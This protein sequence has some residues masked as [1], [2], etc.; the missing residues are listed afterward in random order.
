M[1]DAVRLFY[2]YAHEDEDLRNEL[3]GHLKILERRK[4][5]A[6]WHDRRI[7]P[8]RAWDAEIDRYLREAELV[9]LLVSADFIASDYIMGQELA[10][11]MAQHDAGSSTVVPVI[12]RPVDLQP[13]DVDIA[14]F[15]KLQGLP[16]DLKPVTSWPQRDEAWVLVA[17][18]LRKTVAQIRAKRPAADPFAPP[19]PTVPATIIRP[20]PRVFIS[21]AHADRDTAQAVSRALQAAGLDAALNDGVVAGSDFGHSIERELRA[22]SAVVPAASRAA[23][24]STPPR[25]QPV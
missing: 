22:A 10:T 7:V 17:K 14:P 9:L 12:L 24:R 18:G 21:Y 16:P 15:L 19:A 23:S 13:E 8:G 5:I 1:S 2:S 25:A 3:Q 11:A 4:L 6:P 20:R